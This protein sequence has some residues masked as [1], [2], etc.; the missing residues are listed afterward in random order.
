M[1]EV[2][3]AKEGLNVLNFLQL[4]PIENCL[5]FVSGH[6]EPRQGEDISEVFD[7][8]QM[9]LALLQIE[10][11]SVSTEA[12]EDF[13]DLLAMSGG[14]G[15]VDQYVVEIDHDTH[16]QHICKDTIDKALECSGGVSE[17]EGHY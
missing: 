12:L 3:E 17:T 2:G 8:C 7:G 9:P 4:R 13:P 14:V 5:D 16:I 10:I 11:K 1:I 15:G 6:G